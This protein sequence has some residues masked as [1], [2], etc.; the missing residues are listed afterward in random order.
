MHLTVGTQCDVRSV[1]QQA[2]DL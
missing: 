2:S 1:V